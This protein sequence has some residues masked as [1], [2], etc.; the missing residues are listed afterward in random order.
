MRTRIAG[1]CGMPLSVSP[2]G[3]SRPHLSLREG[4][5]QTPFP[6]AL[7]RVG[8][9]LAVKGSLRRFAPWTAAGRS[10]RRAAYE[11]KGG[12]ARSGALAHDK[13]YYHSYLGRSRKEPFGHTSRL[14]PQPRGAVTRRAVAQRRSRASGLTRPLAEAIRG[15]DSGLGL[16]LLS[17]RFPRSAAV[18]LRHPPAD[19]SWCLR[20]GEKRPCF[21]VNGPLSRDFSSFVG[22]PEAFLARR[23]GVVQL[24]ARDEEPAQRPPEAPDGI[25]RFS[26][27]LSDVGF[28]LCHGTSS[29]L[30]RKHPARVRSLLGDPVATPGPG[31]ADRRGHHR[32]EPTRR[33]DAAWLLFSHVP[34][35]R[36]GSRAWAAALGCAPQER[37]AVSGDRNCG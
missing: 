10:E 7:H 14:E 8:S 32:S 9:V 18:G 28:R 17:V 5:E 27:V 3:R 33:V 19:R 1:I 37:A 16:I 34:Q 25:F 22:G 35:T 12:G 6:L 11:G 21:R 20:K 24:L 4:L 23:I 26:V 31:R 13:G 15:F 30:H 2:W 29:R 36:Q